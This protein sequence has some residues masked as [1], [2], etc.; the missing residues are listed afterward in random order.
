MAVRNYRIQ[1]M[2]MVCDDL[3]IGGHR[4]LCWPSGPF[5]MPYSV[6]PWCIGTFGDHV[7]LKTHRMTSQMME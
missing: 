5:D 6:K 4:L 7:K 1:C 3:V 2:N